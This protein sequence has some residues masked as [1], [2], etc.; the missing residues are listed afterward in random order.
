MLTAAPDQ[1]KMK[2]GTHALYMCVVAETR[3]LLG[4]LAKL[5]NLQRHVAARDLSENLCDHAASIIGE[6]GQKKI[7]AAEWRPVKE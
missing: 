3:R 7:L 6:Q 1:M 4:K 5:K 2:N